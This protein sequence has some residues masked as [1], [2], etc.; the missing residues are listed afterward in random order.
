MSSKAS[1]L[2]VR[3]KRS[4]QSGDIT[5]VIVEGHTEE[6]Y[7]N[8]LARLYGFTAQTRLSCV[9]KGRIRLPW[10]NTQLKFFQTADREIPG[11]NA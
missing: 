2:R 6:K 4:R 10:S 7:F 8:D 3:N 1:T 11:L 9:G 5:L